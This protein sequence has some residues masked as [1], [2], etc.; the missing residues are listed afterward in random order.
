MEEEVRSHFSRES[1]IQLYFD[2]CSIFVHLVRA[3]L[4]SHS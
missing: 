2:V 1:D 4:P 3:V